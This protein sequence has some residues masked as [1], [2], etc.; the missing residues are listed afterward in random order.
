MMLLKD[1]LEREEE[2]IEEIEAEEEVQDNLDSQDKTDKNVS[3]DNQENPESQEN[4]N[5]VRKELNK[6]Q[7]IRPRETAGEEEE[8]SQEK[9][10]NDAMISV[11]YK[12]QLRN[13]SFD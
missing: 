2:V 11:S 8:V 4:P 3:R 10:N 1:K 13:Y 12:Y 7:L 5:K 6:P 9:A